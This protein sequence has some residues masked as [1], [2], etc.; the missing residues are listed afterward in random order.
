MQFVPLHWYHSFPSF[1]H[2]CIIWPFLMALK[3]NWYED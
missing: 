3:H 2:K 1:G